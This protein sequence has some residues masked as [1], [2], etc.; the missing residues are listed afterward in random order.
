MNHLSQSATHIHYS[1]VA[2]AANSSDLDAMA[3]A[4]SLLA[5]PPMKPFTWT[6][7][8]PSI[9]ETFESSSSLNPSHGVAKDSRSANEFSD[10]GTAWEGEG[11]CG[12]GR[13]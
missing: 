3:I 8:P 7:T 2:V 12:R 10:F 4:P 1:L 5:L 11:G 13:C 9:P 6:N